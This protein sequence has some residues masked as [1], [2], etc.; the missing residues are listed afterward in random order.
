LT[1]KYVPL[2]TLQQLILAAFILIDSLGDSTVTSGDVVTCT[3]SPTDSLSEI[4]TS[5]TTITTTPSTANTGTF[6]ESCGFADNAGNTG[7][8]STTYT[9]ELSGGGS[10]SGGGGGSSSSSGYTRTIPVSKDLNG[11]TINQKLEVKERLKVTVDGVFHHIGIKEITA[12]TAVIEIT[13]VPVQVELSIGEDIKVDL[14][15]DNVYD[16]HVKLNAIVNGKADITVTYLSEAYTPPCVPSW[17]CSNY[18]ECVGGTRA[19]ACVDSNSC[20]VNDGKP[21]ESEACSE[22]QQTKNVVW[23]WV[24]IAIVVV[25]IAIGW[26]Y[27]KKKR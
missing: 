9:V 12:T 2:D 23:V 10:S 18:S 19:R 27:M 25:L 16:V 26:V 24:I 17:E 13:S 15:D 22:L 7:I 5:A 8:A 4:N 21:A 3:C 14:N 11:T 20:G 1:D 6:T